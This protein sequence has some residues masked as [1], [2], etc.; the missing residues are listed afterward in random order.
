MGLP[1][2]HHINDFHATTE[3]ILCDPRQRRSLPPGSVAN[4]IDDLL[5]VP[6]HLQQPL[7][8]IANKIQ[9]SATNRKALQDCQKAR[10]IPHC[11][12]SKH[13]AIIFQEVVSNAK[14]AIHPKFV[15]P[16]QQHLHTKALIR[17][18]IHGPKE[19]QAV[20]I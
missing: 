19:P 1:S 9:V 10:T 17:K 11:K 5:Q 16:I 15:D 6:Y 8:R 4:L 2:I 7:W 18:Q 3:H 20:A 12:Y 13:W 14:A